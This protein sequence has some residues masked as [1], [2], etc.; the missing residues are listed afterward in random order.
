MHGIGRIVI[1]QYT[2]ELQIVELYLCK[3]HIHG[4]DVLLTVQ[5]MAVLRKA[6][7]RGH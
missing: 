2:I 6:R 7:S 5:I 3:R 4:G 1:C